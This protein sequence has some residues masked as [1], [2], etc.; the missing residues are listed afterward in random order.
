MFDISVVVRYHS[1]GDISLLKNALFS[2]CVQTRMVEP[3]IIL[4]NCD[5]NIIK[6]IEDYLKILP[7]INNINNHWIILNFNSEDDIRSMMLNKGIEASSSKYVGF[8]DYD[9]IVYQ[10]SYEI[11]ISSMQK[12]NAAVS[13]GGCRKAYLNMNVEHEYFILNKEPYLNRKIALIELLNDN[14]FPIHSYIF[15]KEKIDKKDFY[16]NE[17]L[18]ALEDYELLLRLF[19]SYKFDLSSLHIP[20][21]EYRMRNDETHT[22]PFHDLD[23]INSMPS[24]IYG[25]EHILKLK[26]ELVFN[27]TLDEL[28]KIINDKYGL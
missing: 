11:L 8:L 12:S 1:K 19:A 16:I 17:K 28:N 24:W 5:D 4:H 18:H 22:T 9:D 2:L 15:D 27:H 6:N 23:S 21:A 10:N 20:V 13:F 3:I 25:R 26:Q 7:W 14:F